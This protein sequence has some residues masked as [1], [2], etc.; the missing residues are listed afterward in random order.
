MHLLFAPG[1]R[2]LNLGPEYSGFSLLAAMLLPSFPHHPGQRLCLH[3]PVW[4]NY[5]QPGGRSSSEGVS[6]HGELRM[7]PGGVPG[8]LLHRCPC[9]SAGQLVGLCMD[10]LNDQELGETQQQS[11]KCLPYVGPNL[12]ERAYSLDCDFYM[13]RSLLF[14]VH[15]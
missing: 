15:T 13:T 6:S 10:I 11:K 4:P 3:S 12:P 7:E 5:D 1:L 14:L 8:H 9:S 2:L